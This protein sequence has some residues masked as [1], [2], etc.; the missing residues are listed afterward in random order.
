MYVICQVVSKAVK[1]IKLCEGIERDDM[2]I[3]EIVFK[4]VLSER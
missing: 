1:K 4:S 2:V 3:L